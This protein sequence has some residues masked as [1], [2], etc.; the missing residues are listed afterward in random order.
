M[1]QAEL[2]DRWGRA[3][4]QVARIESA[5]PGSAMLRTINSYVEALGGSCVVV[6]EVE[7]DRFE[8]QMSEG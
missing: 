5:P 3:Q 8:L 2:A 6:I 4:S 7:G 1:T